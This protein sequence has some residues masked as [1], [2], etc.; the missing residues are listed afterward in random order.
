MFPRLPNPMAP[1]ALRAAPDPTAAAVVHCSSGSCP[2][3]SFVD[4]PTPYSGGGPSRLN[5]AVRVASSPQAPRTAQAPQRRRWA[6]GNACASSD[7]P[8]GPS[9]GARADGWI[10]SPRVHCPP[11]SDP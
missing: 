2:P 6:I 10:R 11:E 8:P 3:A 7:P 9:D 1:Q 5:T 4:C